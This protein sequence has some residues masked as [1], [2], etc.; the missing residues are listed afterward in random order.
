MRCACTFVVCN[1]FHLQ[2]SSADSFFFSSE[3]PD[4]LTLVVVRL[5]VVRLFVS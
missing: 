4:R 2:G 5:F 3:E 1:L